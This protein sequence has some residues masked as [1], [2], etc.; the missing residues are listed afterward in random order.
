V[1][2]YRNGELVT[3]LIGGYKNLRAR[4]ERVLR[5]ETIGYD[6]GYTT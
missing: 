6:D 5:G 4:L 3:A 2:Y 1:A